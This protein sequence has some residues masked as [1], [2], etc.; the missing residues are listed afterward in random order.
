MSNSWISKF[1]QSIDN[2]FKV[3]LMDIEVTKAQTSQSKPTAK[4]QIDESK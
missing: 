2:Y 4:S 3:R 1:I